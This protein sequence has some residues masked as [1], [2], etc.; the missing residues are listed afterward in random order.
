[1]ITGKLKFFITAFL[2]SFLFFS[3]VSADTLGQRGTFFVNEEFDKYSRTQLSATLRQVSDKMYF[4]VEDEYWNK[5]NFSTQQ[6]MMNNM[7]KLAKE[8]ETNIYPKE[9]MLWGL[10]PNP[11][12]DGDPKITILLEDLKKT[13]GGYFDTVHGYSR[14]IANDSNER[15]MISLSAEALVSNPDFL[16]VFLAHEFH[17]LIS[18]NQKDLLKKVAEEI[19]L[20]ELRAEYS[21]SVAGY[22]KPYLGSNLENRFNTFLQNPSDSVT[23]WPNVLDDYAMVNAFGQYLA[24]QYGSAILSET[25][26]NNSSV[27]GIPSINEYLRLKGYSEKFEDIFGYWMAAMY[28]NDINKNN[29]LGYLDTDLKYVRIIPQQ[30]I[31]LSSGLAEISLFRFLKPWQPVWWEFDMSSFQGDLS[32]SLK[33][34]ALGETGGLFPVFYLVV[35]N[36]GSIE[37]N[38]LKLNGGSGSAFVISSEKVPSKV[39]VMAT[40]GTKI[41]GFGALESS[42][43]V[44]IDIKVVSTEEAIASVVKDGSLIKRK[45][46]SEIYV[47]WGKYKRYLNPGVISLYGHLDPSKAIEL[48]PEVFHSYTTANYVKYVDKEEVYAVWPEPG[49]GSRGGT[50][51]GIASGTK[52][53][54][55]LT[56]VQW[57]ASGRDWNAIFVINDLELNYYKTG[58]DITR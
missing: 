10:E 43:S 17:H 35:Y 52:H 39:V 48:E 55:S 11:G 15:E 31:N 36:D 3:Y 18:F 24:E 33:L 7:L 47:I 37:F 27:V 2:V 56:P 28:W 12:I 30:Q 6:D 57:D 41:D 22:N 25:L 1:M 21:V 5:I 8:F 9:T 29:R 23:E 32:K 40:N 38:K 14:Q 19:W 58:A 54:I 20:N 16:K 26:K 34:S 49:E 13:N 53:W 4:Y 45:G 42:L 44:R 50:S 51:T 46:E